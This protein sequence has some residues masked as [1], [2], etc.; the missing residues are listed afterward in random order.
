MTASLCF[1]AAPLFSQAQNARAPQPRQHPA[2]PEQNLQNPFEPIPPAPTPAVGPGVIEE[3]DFRGSRRIPQD[4][5]REA[6]LKEAKRVA[7][8]CILL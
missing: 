8:S 4:A 1:S 5:L 6:I 3:V 2:Q 7:S